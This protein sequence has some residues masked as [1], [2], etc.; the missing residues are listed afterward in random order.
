[1]VILGSLLYTAGSAFQYVTPA[2]LGEISTQ[3]GINEAQ[4][5]SITAAENVGVALAS[6]LSVLCLTRV[7]RRILALAG[8][9]LCVILNLGAFFIR[10]VELLIIARFCT[11]LVGEGILFALAFVVLG[12]TRDPDRSFGIGLTSVVTFGSL[13]LGTSTY[14]DRVPHG[15]GILLP[16]AIVP[17]GVLLAVHWMPR[18]RP[19]AA[20][21]GVA[22][23]S[24]GSGWLPI[25]AIAGMMI[26]FAAP[27]A[28]WTFA[29]S[30][31]A[32]RGIPSGTISV[33]LAVGNGVGLLGSAVAAW[34]GDRWGRFRPLV[35]ATVCLCVSVVAFEQSGS[36]VALASAL[37]AFNAFWN[38]AAV[39]EMALVA[40]LDPGG[41]ASL[42]IS[43]AQVMGFAAGGLLSGLAISQAG[44]GVLP[45]VVAAL[46]VGGMLVLGA[47]SRMTV[48]S[49][50]TVP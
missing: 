6:L 2:Y 7:N 11:G 3:L 43:A 27:G 44:Y 9:A 17:L 39:Y 36:A 24:T 32:A 5:G 16:L 13:V 47:P 33:A 20:S 4:M 38:Y 45:L 34:Q 30:A 48:L 22:A 41:R 42:A 40:A 12:S 21:R 46:A 10:N 8:A 49:Q 1:M 19:A 50:G 28:F 23:T 37:S 31:A 26:W 29:E 15:T 25:V 35:V 14:L 18:A